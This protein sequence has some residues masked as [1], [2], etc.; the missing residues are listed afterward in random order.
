MFKMAVLWLQ[1][2]CKTRGNQSGVIPDWCQSGHSSSGTAA[3]GNSTSRDLAPSLEMPPE[4]H[5]P[6]TSKLKLLFLSYFHSTDLVLMDLQSTTSLGHWSARDSTSDSVLKWRSKEVLV[7]KSVTSV[8]ETSHLK[9][10]D[11][12]IVC[13]WG[14]KAV[15]LPRWSLT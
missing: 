3:Y 5:N 9:S 12:W 6:K 2:A 1:Q 10:D 11:L 4:Y 15:G 8:D 14:Y 7:F 13:F